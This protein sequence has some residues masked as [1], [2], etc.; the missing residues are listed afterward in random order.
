MFGSV[1]N[2]PLVCIQ[3]VYI[4]LSVWHKWV[5]LVYLRIISMCCNSLNT[6]NH[7]KQ[8]QTFIIIKQHIG[9]I[10]TLPITLLI[11]SSPPCITLSR[12]FSKSFS[13]FQGPS[14]HWLRCQTW[15]S[16]PIS[17]PNTDYMAR[18]PLYVYASKSDINKMDIMIKLYC[19]APT[20]PT[21][22]KYE[23]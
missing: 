19:E 23:K 8:Q 6:S 10:R 22:S 12:Y 4:E 13:L 20:K 3:R 17:G 14:A 2:R 16:I 5:A 1:L 11:F 18:W 21:F 7:T 9:L 15:W